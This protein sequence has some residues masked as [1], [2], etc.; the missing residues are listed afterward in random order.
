MIT[1]LVKEQQTLGL[2]TRLVTAWQQEGID[3]LWPATNQV[4]RHLVSAKRYAEAYILFRSMI[5]VQKAGETGYVFNA[6]FKSQ[7]TGNPFDWQFKNQAGVL[8]RIVRLVNET[9]D[10]SPD[11]DDR[12]L[13]IKFL[14][15]P[16]QFD[17]LSQLM[18]LIPGDYNLAATYQT[19]ELRA[20]KPLFLAVE[21][22]ESKI[23]LTVL[24]FESGTSKLNTVS[25]D[26]RIPAQGCALQRIHMFNEFLARSWSNRYNGRLTLD[27]IFVR[28]LDQDRL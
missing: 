11:K 4:T 18:R 23:K 5:D 17:A 25:N 9:G 6:D 13:Q 12:A 2:A 19:T 20:P 3:G 22:I 7:P 1:S 15:N 14:D 24:P 28:R 21:C 27:R 8:M 16:V 26:F 10:A